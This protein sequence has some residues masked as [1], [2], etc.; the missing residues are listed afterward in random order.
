MYASV[1]DLREMLRNI[2]LSEELFTGVEGTDLDLNGQSYSI[3]RVT[4]NGNVLS[5]SQYQF[6]PPN[7][8][9]LAVSLVLSD[10]VV[11]TGDIGKPNSDLDRLLESADRIIDEE[12]DELH[13]SDPPSLFTDIA[14]WLA[15]SLYL[16]YYAAQTESEQKRA[17]ILHNRAAS[18]LKRHLEDSGPV[19]IGDADIT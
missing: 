15:G 4:L 9:I 10:V 1:I 17:S 6:I 16:S 11:V 19:V 18:A 8:L 14:K 12:R 7:K 3:S 13:D 2:L 5:E